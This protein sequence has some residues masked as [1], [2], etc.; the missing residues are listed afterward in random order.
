[1]NNKKSKQLLLTLTAFFISIGAFAGKLQLPLGMGG[2]PDIGAI[3]CGVFNKMIVAGPL[4]TK[5]LLLTWAEGYYFAQTGKTLDQILQASETAGKS[6]NFEYL[7]EYFVTYCAKDP[8]ALT[9]A[10]VADLGHTILKITP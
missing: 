10:A 5:R 7:T 3:P 4:G 6:W 1:M 9:S 8:E 2:V